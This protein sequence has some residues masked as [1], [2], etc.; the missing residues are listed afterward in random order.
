MKRIKLFAGLILAILSFSN[1][2]KAQV[3]E[4]KITYDSLEKKF[5][6]VNYKFDADSLEGFDWENAKRIAEQEN[7]QGFDYKFF[8]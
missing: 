1:V 8:M 5:S 7:L 3:N 4:N 2:I 6:F